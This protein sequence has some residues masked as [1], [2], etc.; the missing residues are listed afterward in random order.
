MTQ[1]QQIIDRCVRVLEEKL[2]TN[3]QASR[4]ATSM[5]KRMVIYQENTGIATAIRILKTEKRRG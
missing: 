1:T 4:K 3:H 5:R 2:K